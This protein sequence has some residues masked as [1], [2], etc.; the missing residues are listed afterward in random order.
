MIQIVQSSQK[1]VLRLSFYPRQTSILNSRNI[2]SSDIC[3]PKD[4]NVVKH[5][6]DWRCNI[7]LF[8]ILVLWK[9]TTIF[10]QKS[11]IWFRTRSLPQFF[12]LCTLCK[13]ES[14][15]KRFLCSYFVRY[16]SKRYEKIV[17][18]LYYIYWLGNIKPW[19]K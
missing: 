5:N 17:F 7:R 15:N 13:T 3:D 4:C 6:F 18:F 1:T 10:Q 16:V 11:Y 9:Q 14:Y 12:I 2:I 8:Y 19:T